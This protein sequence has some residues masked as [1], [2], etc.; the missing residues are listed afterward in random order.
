MAAFITA[1]VSKKTDTSFVW[2]SLKI[3]KIH[4]GGMK[5]Q[6]TDIDL[7][8]VLYNHRVKTKSH[9]YCF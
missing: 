2:L 1:E 7:M 5:M 4:I 6:E 8:L 3:Q 9:M